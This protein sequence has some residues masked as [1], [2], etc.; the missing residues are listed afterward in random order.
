MDFLKRIPEQWKSFSSTK[1]SVSLVIIACL[2][3]SSYFFYRWATKVEYATLYTNVQ[4]DN[5]GKIVEGLKGL[6]VPYSLTDEGKTISVPKDQVYEVRLSLASKGVVSEGGKG[7]ELFD[8]SNMG[9]TDFEINV[10]YQRALQEELRRSI[11][12]INAVKQAR[13]HLVLPQ[14][15]A[16]IENQNKPQASIILELKP[17]AALQPEQVKGIAELVAGSVENLSYEDVNIIDTEG[18]VLSDSIK[19]QGNTASQLTQMELKKSFEKD[20]E[21]RIQ[22]LLESIYGSDKIVA[23]VTANLDF[24]QKEADRTIWGNQ[25]VVASEQNSQTQTGTTGSSGLVGTAANVGPTLSTSS[26][27]AN[28]ANT[29]ISSTKNYEINK[30]EEKEI[31]APG[32]VISISVAVAVDGNPNTSK[33]A[34][35]KNVVSAAI[36]FDASR[37]DTINVL[38]TMFDKSSLIAAKAEMA[39]ADAAAKKQAQMDTWKSWGYKGAGVLAFLIIGFLL[40]RYLKPRDDWPELRIEQP[41]SIKKVEEQMEQKNAYTMEQ[42]NAYT[43]EDEKIKKIL[44]NEPDVAVQIITSWLEDGGDKIG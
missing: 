34:R 2:I 3:L 42:K 11:V 7:F 6:N 36:G 25:G 12:Q 32:R 15:S 28:N 31:Y 20:L 22:Q 21:T 39:K 37:G 24:N 17:L 18:H 9:A 4:A 33:T 41:I 38:G 13:V 29:N 16:F 10:N 40:M 5:A 44:K 1:K 14:K 8:T 27:G 19:N 23:M 43:N 26:S 30:V 35:I